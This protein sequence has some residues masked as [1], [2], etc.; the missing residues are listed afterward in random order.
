[1]YLRHRHVPI[2]VAGDSKPGVAEDWAT[3]STL[4]PDFNI[5]VA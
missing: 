2:D 4:A 3:T 5:A 1:M